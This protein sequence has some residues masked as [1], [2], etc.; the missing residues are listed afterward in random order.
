MKQDFIKNIL[1]SMEQ[2]LSK[3]ELDQLETMLYKHLEGL[4]LVELDSINKSNVDNMKLIE[5]FISAKKIEGCSDKTL[6]YYKNTLTKLLLKVNAFLLFLLAFF[7][8]FFQYFQH[9]SQVHI[10]YIKYNICC[11]YLFFIFLFF[12]VFFPFIS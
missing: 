6:K 9:F 11:Q 3:K 8:C 12:F 2:T 5:Q 1:Y 7:Q 10:K 4:E